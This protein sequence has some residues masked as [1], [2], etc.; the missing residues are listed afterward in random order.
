MD[1]LGECDHKAR[2]TDKFMAVTYNIFASSAGQQGKG[3]GRAGTLA[4]SGH[5]WA[6][7][8]PWY[9]SFL[10]LTI[11]RMSVGIC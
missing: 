11:W 8:Q 7:T 3:V 10:S 1:R 6:S 4:E 2:R 5:G 9:L